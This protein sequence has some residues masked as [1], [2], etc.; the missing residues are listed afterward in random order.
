MC[1][2][3]ARWRQDASLYNHQF[4]FHRQD[5]Q[6]VVVLCLMSLFAVVS[7]Q[8]VR[9]VTTLWDE[10][11]D[12]PAV[13]AL[14]Q[15]P[16]WGTGELDSE[17]QAW[18]PMY[19]TA[20]VFA[21]TGESLPAAR[22]LSIGVGALTILM[23]WVAGRR[24]FRG[25]VALFAAALLALSP[26]F[27]SFSRTGMTEGDAFCPLT[28]LLAL[29]AFDAYMRWRNSQSILCLAVALGLAMSAKF[30]VV[31]LMPAL[32]VCDLVQ[33]RA[34][35]SWQGDRDR[36]AYRALL[37]WIMA[38]AGL[39]CLA[40]SAAQG[41]QVPLSIALWAAGVIGMLLA[42]ARLLTQRAVRWPPLA[43]WLAILL[44][45]TTVCLA[46]F[47]A[48]VLQPVV[49]QQLLSRSSHWDGMQPLALL[50][51]HLRLYSGIILLKLGVPL[52]LLSVAALLWACVRAW[53]HTV[54]RWMVAVLV[55]YLAML[56]TLPLRQPF[57]LMSI[58][59]LL[60]LIVS[61]FLV[62][63]TVVLQPWGILQ[64]VW[65]V[66]AV[67]AHLWLIWG[68][69]HVYPAFGWYGYETIGER[70]L[71]EESRGYRNIIQVTNDGT[72]DSLR[73]VVDHVPAGARVVSY[74]SDFHVVEAFAARHTLPF[75]FIQR[76]G[77]IDGA[78]SLRPGDADYFLVDLNTL[79]ASGLPLGGDGTWGAPVHTIWRGRGRY[80]MPAVQIYPRQ[81]VIYPGN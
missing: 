62:E 70:W 61:C 60:V 39:E 40:L 43:A 46:A 34:A 63:M 15:H 35:P 47:P 45:A 10:Q 5:V 71:G 65:I 73:W 9:G 58:Y 78:R 36:R 81:T 13:T 24:W 54:L 12:W 68:V 41:H 57:Y 38:A 31:A 18:L 56:V 80:R 7:W 69:V 6:C 72:E 23:T 22:M 77:D 75:E 26:Y 64:R 37:G 1:T 14:V 29:L 3:V 48:H 44:L 74:L 20:V 66:T 53:R 52:G 50:G 32:L 28:V 27:I 11:Q 59:P 51:E 76:P 67:A 19:A 30:F 25:T 55:I 21:F 17:A 4:S 49:L 2:R 79:I 42:A 33:Y 16:L 8:S